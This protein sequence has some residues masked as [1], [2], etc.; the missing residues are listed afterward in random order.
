M[1]RGIEGDVQE[2]GIK[3][4]KVRAIF[5]IKFLKKLFQSI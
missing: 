1:K 5:F 3:V 4:V 2:F